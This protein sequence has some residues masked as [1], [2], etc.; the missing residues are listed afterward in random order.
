MLKRRIDAY[1]EQTAPLVDYYRWQGTLK[2][3]DGMPAI[4]EVAAA[5]DRALTEQP[6]VRK[7]APKE[8]SPAKRQARCQGAAVRNQGAGQETGKGR[9]RLNPK[10]RL[11]P[12]PR[13]AKPKTAAAKAKA[14]AP[15]RKAA[16]QAA[17]AGQGRSPARGKAAP[18]KSK[19]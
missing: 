14:K 13:P 7:P 9:S 6:P 17:K 8:T 18:R 2:S 4:D 11:R 19:R 5:I 3:V 1:R 12:N 16:A 10:R 15:A